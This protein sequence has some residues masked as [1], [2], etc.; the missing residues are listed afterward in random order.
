MP[1]LLFVDDEEVMRK[2]G[3]RLLAGSYELLFAS[4]TVEAL[5]IIASAGRLDLLVT[6]W[7][8]QDGSGG[9]IVRAFNHKFPGAPC[10]LITGF[11]NTDDFLK[12]TSGLSLAARFQKPFNILEFQD[13]VRKLLPETGPG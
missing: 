3:S 2:L 4:G 8:L 11:L 9:D 10:V 6:D 1:K 12:E 7:R 5:G 13:A